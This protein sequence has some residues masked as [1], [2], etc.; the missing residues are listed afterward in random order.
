M[1]RRRCA[2]RALPVRLGF[3][4]RD[5]RRAGG[6]AVRCLRARRPDA[7]LERRSADAGRERADQG[8]VGLTI[9]SRANTQT[10]FHGP[11][12]H[13]LGG[14]LVKRRALR[15][16]SHVGRE[17]TGGFGVTFSGVSARQRW[18]SPRR[19]G[20]P[21]RFLWSR[22][23]SPQFMTNAVTIARHEAEREGLGLAFSNGGDRATR[24]RAPATIVRCSTRSATR[25]GRT[26]RC[27][28]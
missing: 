24:T 4:A 26:Q 1:P 9:R 6:T 2:D 10:G 16:C 15:T 25:S 13:A 27:S 8:A 7:T 18:R 14:F 20:R 28:A 21:Q 3:P 17:G 5:G 11:R 23:S 22:L 12:R 19:T